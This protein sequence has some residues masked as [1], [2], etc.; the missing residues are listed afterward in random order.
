MFPEPL[1][2]GY[3]ALSF[4]CIT[5][6]R[7]QVRCSVGASLHAVTIISNFAFS[8]CR[9]LFWLKGTIAIVII[10]SIDSVL[11]LRVWI[12]YD[13]NRRLLLFLV[14]LIITEMTSM[15]LIDQF[16]VPTSEAFEHIGYLDMLISSPSSHTHSQNRPILPGC[17]SK[18]YSR[19]SVFFAVPPLIVSFAMFVMTIYRCIT[20]LRTGI[21][22]RMPI[23][24]LFLR[25]GVFWFVAVLIAVG[26]IIIS[27]FVG[28]P[29]LLDL[30]SSPTIVVFSVIAS[31]TLLN[32]KR[33]LR[34]NTA[35]DVL[36]DEYDLQHFHPASDVFRAL[37]QLSGDI[38]L[39]HPH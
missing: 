18:T 32:M 1:L 22:S 27:W 13:R 6:S 17:Q 31:H 30:M 34:A 9:A 11:A 19:L 26:G 21:A 5:V 20:T 7:D 25:D 16:L 12:L 10:S 23:T 28:R 37:D 4:D 8:S 35:V 3:W 24:S 29:T 33:L 2:L 15:L 39:Q 14:P 38:E 36:G